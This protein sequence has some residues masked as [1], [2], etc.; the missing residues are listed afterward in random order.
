M[1]RIVKDKFSTHIL[2]PYTAAISKMSNSAMAAKS[3]STSR[4]KTP[5]VETHRLAE[6]A[7]LLGRRTDDLTDDELIQAVRLADEDRDA[8]RERVGRLLAALYLRGR[9]SWP[10]LGELTGIPYGTAHGL[11]R[12]YIPREEDN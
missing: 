2:E 8:A 5:C 4:P 9:L 10:K 12:P 11:A 7:A 1:I 3:A 6:R